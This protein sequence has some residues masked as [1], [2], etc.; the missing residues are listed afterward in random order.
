LEPDDASSSGCVEAG[1]ASPQSGEAELEG[2]FGSP[3]LDELTDCDID[4]LEADA[5]AADEEEEDE[6][7]YTDARQHASPESVCNLAAVVFP[8]CVVAVGERPLA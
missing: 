2:D 6:P 3:D 8:G 1:L 5:A 4:P 7:L